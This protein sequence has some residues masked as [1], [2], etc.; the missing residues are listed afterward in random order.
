MLADP[1]RAGRRHLP[2][3]IGQFP[4]ARPQRQRAQVGAVAVQQVEGVEGQLACAAAG[5]RILQRRERASPLPVERHQF[6]VEHEVSGRQ[7]CDRLGQRRHPRGPVEGR[8]V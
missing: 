8:C 4:L 3:Q 6:A 1:D 5:Q 2:E 7:R